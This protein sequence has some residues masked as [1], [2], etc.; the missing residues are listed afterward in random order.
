MRSLFLF[1]SEINRNMGPVPKWYLC[2]NSNRRF[3]ET[4][5]RHAGKYKFICLRKFYTYISVMF[6]DIN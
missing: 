1:I 5:A 4:L 3:D 6:L 2:F